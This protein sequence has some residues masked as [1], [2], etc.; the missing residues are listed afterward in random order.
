MKMLTLGIVFVL[1]ATTLVADEPAAAKKNAL[2]GEWLLVKESTSGAELAQTLKENIQ[3]ITFDT[4]SIVAGRIAAYKLDEAKKQIDVTIDG[5]PKS[6]QG[7]YLGIYELNGDSLKLHLAMPGQPRPTG[8]ES[9]KETI[10]IALKRGK[11]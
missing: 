5:G 8:Y 9:T 2:L 6:E 4:E 3:R 10:L 7:I 1:F 11:S